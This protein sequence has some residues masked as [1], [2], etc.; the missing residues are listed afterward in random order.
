MA[1]TRSS[2]SR[3][4]QLF[5]F[6]ILSSMVNLNA[7]SIYVSVK[8]DDNN[9]GLSPSFP[10]N[11]PQLAF[12]LINAGDT[13]F[14][15]E[16]EYSTA[17][18]ESILKIT[19][20]GTFE[21]WIHIHN[22]RNDKVVLYSYKESAIIIK[23]AAYISI[24]GFDIT[25][26]P[27]SQKAADNSTN[28]S[29]L[30]QK[31]QGIL[32]DRSADN[33]FSHDITISR[34]KIHNCLGS[35]IQLNDIYNFNL[36]YNEIY[37]NGYYNFSSNSGIKISMVTP[38]DS[39]SLY[40]NFINGNKIY[41]HRRLKSDAKIEDDCA[42]KGNGSG[43]FIRKSNNSRSGMNATENKSRV[44]ISN[45]L[46]YAN[47][48]IGINLYN[49]KNID[50]FNNTMYENNEAN[51]FDCAD[52]NIRFASFINVY[53]NIIISRDN[54]KASFYINAQDIFF[55]NNLYRSGTKFENG[56][57]DIVSDPLFVS[58]DA[59]TNSWDFNLQVESPAI[60]RGIELVSLQNDI[61]LNPRKTG[62]KMDIGAVEYQK[63]IAGDGRMPSGFRKDAGIE[64][65][66]TLTYDPKRQ[67][68]TVT[69]QSNQAFYY[70]IYD[71][72]YRP[73]RKLSHLDYNDL[74]SIEIPLK[75][76]PK[77]FY[78]MR[79]YTDKKFFVSKFYKED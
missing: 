1:L 58:A 49:S 20:S 37:N 64:F 41:F 38:P 70:T 9:N 51:S 73:V 21:K 76:L 60:D 15:M 33:T 30:F 68:Y 13:L 18:G 56:K 57:G 5:I 46:I 79:V 26:D 19:K 40:Q 7:A 17:N 6:L 52:L 36:Q 27:K 65:N 61:N 45:N 43:I 77:G 59:F 72:F 50:V 75:N 67:L 14:F 29:V 47:G 34:C 22:Y 39:S 63:P 28:P 2:T 8:G 78:F 69:N 31:G 53:N 48:G 24:F 11:T 35:G 42:L 55:S 32:V 23:G 25:K 44:L 10:K 66:W 71:I 74:Y 12:D 16:G 62:K 54:R 4:V 3:L